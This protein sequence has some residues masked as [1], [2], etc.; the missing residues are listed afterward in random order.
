MT[1]AYALWSTLVRAVASKARLAGFAAVAVLVVV[2]AARSGSGVMLLVDAVAFVDAVGVSFAAP[3]AALVF[4][5]GVLGDLVDDGTLVYLWLRPVARWRLA[6]SAAFASW[7]LAVPAAMVPVLVGCAVLGTPDRLTAAAVLAT[8]AAVSAYSSLFVWLG[9]ISRRALV[10][11]IGYLLIVE[12]F[13]ARG[14]AGLGALSV[15]SHALSILGGR[16]D[17]EMP[18][19]W[20]SPITSGIVLALV[21]V[22]GVVATTITLR[23]RDLA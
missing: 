12:Q 10:W 2:V 21:T 6:V 23:L 5:V 20:F 1:A 16:T 4:G 14:G 19:A 9:L 13:A 3:V 8:F 22:A 18:T 17:V 11:G 15:R 7:T